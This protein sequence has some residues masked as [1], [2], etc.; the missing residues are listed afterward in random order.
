MNTHIEAVVFDLDATLINLGEYVDWNA[1]QK[2]VCTEYLNH[3]CSEE[4]VQLNSSHGLF[5][6][7][8][9]MHD[10]IIL[11][12]GL[13]EAYTIQE[14]IF[15]IIDRYEADGIKCGLMPG[16]FEALEWLD[17]HDIT[18]GICTSNSTNIAI[19]SFFR[20][21]IGRTVGLKLKPYPDQVLA[22]FNMLG[23]LPGRGV[24]VGDSHNDVL[25]GKAAGA[26]T[27]AVPV[28]FTHINEMNAAKPDLIIKNLF[29]LPLAITKLR[30]K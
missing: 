17:S 7:L 11:S 2:H 6:L 16:T 20:S 13:V 30:T 12:K 1:A 18:L 24:M 19:K 23:I 27:I 25:A 3:G 21:I 26:R 5:N 4:T 9:A 10:S 15:S 28:Y 22:C 29:E 8:G 14:N